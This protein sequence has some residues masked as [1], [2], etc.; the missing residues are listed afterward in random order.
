MEHDYCSLKT[1]CICLDELH[2]RNISILSCGHVF[3]FHCIQ[4]WLQLPKQDCPLCREIISEGGKQKI[5]IYTP[6]SFDQFVLERL[7]RFPD[8]CIQE[9]IDALRVV[10]GG[11]EDAFA[12]VRPNDLVEQ[13]LDRNTANDLTRAIGG[14]LEPWWACLCSI[15]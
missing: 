15:D 12:Y 8:L 11:D 5:T 13:G 4:G 7:V 6:P 3:H 10:T 1:C 2:D 14:H 9:N